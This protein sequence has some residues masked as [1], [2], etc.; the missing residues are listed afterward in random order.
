MS[1]GHAH[2]TAV[3][4]SGRHKRPLLIAFSLTAVFT[5]VE[6]VAGFAFNSLALISDAGHMLT[7]VAGIGMALAAIQVAQS[8][9]SPSAT[10][11]L[12]RLEVLAALVNTLLLFG[13][14]AYVLVE[15]WQRLQNPADIP[16]VALLVV[17]TIGL[18]VNVASFLVLRPGAKESINVR[19]ASLEVLSDMLG[20][21]GVIVAGLVLV[22]TGWPYVDS[23]VGAAIGLF[24][25]PRAYR[26]GREALHVLLEMAPRDVDVNRARLRLEGVSGVAGVHDF[27]VWTLTSGLRV[28]TGHLDL[29]AGADGESVRKAA[30]AVLGDEIGIEHVTLQLEPEG[31][32]EHASMVV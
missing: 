2:P 16:G 17:A 1:E 19:G 22:F 18:A 25:L 10:Y 15:A 3:S 12:Y 14:A 21:I 28:A 30:Q 6:V 11:G 9:R 7:D 24:I 32:G 5:V 23:I 13:I 29:A 20:S 26:L 27:H 8:H 31:A 4:A